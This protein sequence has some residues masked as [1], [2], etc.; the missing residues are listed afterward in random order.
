MKLESDEIAHALTHL[1][2]ASY[3]LLEIVDAEPA[4]KYIADWS[5]EQRLAA[6]VRAD[7]EEV[8]QALRRCGVLVE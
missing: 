4:P 1:Y 6:G 3:K 2:W 8:E 7:L 5:P